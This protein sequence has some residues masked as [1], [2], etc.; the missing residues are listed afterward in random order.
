MGFHLLLSLLQGRFGEKVSTSRSPS[1]LQLPF[2][3]FSE[4]LSQCLFLQGGVDKNH[5]AVFVAVRREGGL[6]EWW[7]ITKEEEEAREELKP[8]F[9]AI[10]PLPRHLFPHYS[11]FIIRWYTV[12]G[13]NVTPGRLVY[14]QCLQRPR[15]GPIAFQ[16]IV[17]AERAE[18]RREYGRFGCT[19]I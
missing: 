14:L 3:K 12:F 19:A 9:R 8:R 10:F 13:R 5:P 4:M 17:K 18:Q 2:F 6:I 7:G 1:A 16:T 11:V 15:V